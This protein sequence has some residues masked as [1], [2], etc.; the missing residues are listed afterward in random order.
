M[1]DV[2]KQLEDK[3]GKFFSLEDDAKKGIPGAYIH[4]D[5]KDYYLVEITS[6]IQSEITKAKEEVYTEAKDWVKCKNPVYE[7][8]TIRPCYKCGRDTKFCSK[9]SLDHHV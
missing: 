6:S 9:C 5:G 8:E 4:L 3:Y 1:D 2:I 7:D